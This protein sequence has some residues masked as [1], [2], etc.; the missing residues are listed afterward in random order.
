MTKQT[1]FFTDE[2]NEIYLNAT[3]TRLVNNVEEKQ[4]VKL[5]LNYENNYDLFTGDADDLKDITIK[6]PIYANSTEKV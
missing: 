1:D 2:N 3:L 4:T 6:G 5:R